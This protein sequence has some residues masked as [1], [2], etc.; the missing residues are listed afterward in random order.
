MLNDVSPMQ[1]KHDWLAAKAR[2]VNLRVGYKVRRGRP[3]A[4]RVHGRRLTAV[5]TQWPPS[6]DLIRTAGAVYLLWMAHQVIRSLGVCRP[7]PPSRHSWIL[8]SC[9]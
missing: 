1:S 8:F 3:C 9:T 6:F 4:N 2:Q 5:I 7:T